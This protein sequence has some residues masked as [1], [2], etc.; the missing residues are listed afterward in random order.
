MILVGSFKR[1][2]YIVSHLLITYNNI[3]LLPSLNFTVDSTVKVSCPYNTSHPQIISVA[4]G[5]ADYTC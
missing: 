5:T 2:N 4:A 3:F 1:D